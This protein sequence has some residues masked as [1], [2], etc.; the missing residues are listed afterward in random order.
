MLMPASADPEMMTNA[1]DE[2]ITDCH[3]ELLILGRI[4]DRHFV[5]VDTTDAGY[6]GCSLDG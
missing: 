4:A 6:D 5:K 3:R 1:I 2:M